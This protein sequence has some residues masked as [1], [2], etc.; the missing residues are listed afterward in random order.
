MEEV[1]ININDKIK[2]R[3][4]AYGVDLFSKRYFDINRLSDDLYGRRLVVNTMPEIDSDGYTQFQ[5]HDFMALYGQHMVM[6]GKAVLNDM[7]IIVCKGD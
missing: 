1:K 2:V 5:L 6:G 3:L 7:N 4:S